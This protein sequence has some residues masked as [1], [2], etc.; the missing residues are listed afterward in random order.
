MLL[1]RFRYHRIPSSVFQNFSYHFV[2]YFIISVIFVNRRNQSVTIM[3]PF[4]G[5]LCLL[6]VL[7]GCSQ[8]DTPHAS[9]PAPVRIAP[10]I[11]RVTGLDFDEGDRIGLRIDK[12]DGRYCENAALSYDGACFASEGLVWYDDPEERSTLTGY[13]PYSPAGMPERFGVSA[14]QRTH[15]AYVASDLLLARAE[16]VAPSSTPVPLVFDHLLCKVTVC[17]T[18]RTEETVSSVSL[19]GLRTDAT[20]DLEQGKVRADLSASETAI[21]PFPREEGCY[22]AIV[23]PQNVSLRLVVATSDG[24]THIRSFQAADLLAGSRYTIDATLTKTM[25]TARLEGSI[26]DWNEGGALV[27][28]GEEKPAE[29]AD[30]L[31]YEGVAYRT[32]TLPTGSVW[33]AENLRYAPPGT[34]ASPDAGSDAGIWLPCTL[35]LVASEDA[36]YIAAQGLLYDLETA[37]GPSAA[38]NGALRPEGVRGVCPEGWHIPTQADFTELMEHGAA[39]EETF[40]SFAGIRDATGKYTGQKLNDGFARSYF[41][42]STADEESEA[43]YLCL[44]FAKNGT[45]SLVGMD[46]ATGLPLRCVKDR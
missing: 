7:E 42:G 35:S 13:Y 14:D 17:L 12:A 10:T 9:T 43:S 4:A 18:N 40:F 29:P 22:E 24:T 31:L 30:D 32:A 16:Q 11:T 39:L 33:M 41:L 27:P 1:R 44:C 37:A 6:L 21:Y 25:L 38:Q 15:E 8:N 5:I 46:A 2:A 36:E 28:E 20:V 34:P 19:E 45:R 3:R 26:R 23:V